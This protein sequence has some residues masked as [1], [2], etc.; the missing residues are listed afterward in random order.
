M[1]G[2]ALVVGYEVYAVAR[3]R[4]TMSAAFRRGRS[5]PLRRA[6]MVAAWTVLTVHLFEAV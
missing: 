2:W 4:E 1:V 3:R 5:R 6:A